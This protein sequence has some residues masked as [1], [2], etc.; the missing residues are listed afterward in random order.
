MLFS[1]IAIELG[2]SLFTKHLTWPWPWLGR[3]RLALALSMKH[4][5]MTHE[6]RLRLTEVMLSFPGIQFKLKHRLNSNDNVGEDCGTI[7]VVVVL[8]LLLVVVVVVFL[9]TTK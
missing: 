3:W 9:L 6:T 1:R 4:H 7:T 5:Y 8:L 2:A